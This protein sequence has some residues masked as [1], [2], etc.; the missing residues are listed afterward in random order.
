M[1]G[2]AA[3]HR[4]VDGAIGEADDAGGE[5]EQV[6]QPDHGKQRQKA[7]DI[8]LRL[9]A[10]DGHQRD[11]HRDDAG[12]HQQHQDDAAAPPRRFVRHERLGG[13]IVVGFGGHLGRR[14]LSALDITRLPRAGS[15]VPESD[16]QTQVHQAAICKLNP[17]QAGFCP[18][19]HTERPEKV[20]F[21]P[22][23]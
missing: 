2:D 9:G 19:G 7:E 6:E 11:R 23:T 16:L 4:I 5:R 13:E 3:H 14:G 21:R 1:I 15:S 10:A 20:R 8:G 22:M 17:F 18:S 12:G